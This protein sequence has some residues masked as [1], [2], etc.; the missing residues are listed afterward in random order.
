MIR[1]FFGGLLVALIILTALE[2]LGWVFAYVKD[3]LRVPPLPGHPEYDV[4]CS[5]GD[6]LKLCPDQG[7][8]YER[9]RPEVFTSKSTQPRIIF[10]GESLT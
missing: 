2:G 9:V 5:W 4:V 1:K 7:P 8:S 6:M 10:I 3:D